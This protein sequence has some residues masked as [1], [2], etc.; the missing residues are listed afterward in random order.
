MSGQDKDGFCTFTRI[1]DIDKIKKMVSG[2]CRGVVIGGGLIGVAAA[3]ALCNLGVQVTIVELRGWLLNQILNQEAARIV[4]DTVRERGINI[5]TG[6]SV[7]EV[8]GKDTAKSMVGGVIL[9]D[10]KCL[11]A[12]L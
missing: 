3:E 5:I 6:K 9:S 2:T 4:E 1:D 8:I 11:I 7:Q 10:G 12:I